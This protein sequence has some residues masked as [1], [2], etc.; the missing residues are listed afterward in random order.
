MSERTRPSSSAIIAGRLKKATE[1][2][3]AAGFLAD[4]APD[5]AVNLYVLSGIA[6]ADVVCCVRLNKYVIGDNHNEAV[7]LLKQADGSLERH[8]LTL[9]AIKSKVAYTHQSATA[10][11]RKKARRAAEGLERAARLAAGLRD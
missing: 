3:D 8:L 10:G 11:E 5:A 7:S 2:L 1:F 9:L 4:D 6:A